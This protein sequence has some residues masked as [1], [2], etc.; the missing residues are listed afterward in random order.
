ME[1]CGISLRTEKI[2]KV[3]RIRRRN[4]Q[5]GRSKDPVANVL[6][7]LIKTEENS[8]VLGKYDELRGRSSGGTLVLGY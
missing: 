6:G 7:R 3:I 2:Q 1:F 8:L 4:Q 5:L